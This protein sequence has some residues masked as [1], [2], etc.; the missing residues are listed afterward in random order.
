MNKTSD[1]LSKEFCETES[2]KYASRGS[3]AKGCPSAYNKARLKGWLDEYV[4]L[5]PQRHE[6]GYWTEARCESI[7]RSY[8]RMY[9]FQTENYGA[10]NAAK[11]NGWL[12][13]YTWLEMVFPDMKPRGY[14]EDYQNCF[15]EA[16]RHKTL[17]SFVRDSGGA[18]NSA[19]EHGWL[20]DY[21]WL[22]GNRRKKEDYYT[23]DVCYEIAKS[24]KNK[25]Q[26]IRE[27]P[28]AY[29]VSKENGWVEDYTWLN[30][31]KRKQ[32]RVQTGYWTQKENCRVE[33]L[34]YTKR[35]E[36]R[37]KSN[38][39]Y[40][41]SVKNG[42]I[43]E[44][45]WLE[46]WDNNRIWTKEVCERDARRFTRLAD[47]RKNSKNSY[48]AAKKNGWLPEMVWLERSGK[49][50]GY[51]NEKTCREE[52]L[53]HDT[54]KSFRDE[55]GSGYNKALEN[56]W[57]KEYTWLKR[58]EKKGQE[59]ILSEEK[60]VEMHNRFAKTTEQFIEEAR[61]VHGDKYDYSKTVYV[62]NC[63]KVCIICPE[64]GEFWQTPK[65]HLK[66]NGCAKC[67]FIATGN[68]TRKGQEQFLKEVK[69]VWG[70]ELDFSKVEYKSSKDLVCVVCHKKDKDGKEHGEFYPIP[71]NLLNGHGCPKC[72]IEKNAE[73]SRKDVNKLIEEIHQIHGEKYKI[74]DLSEYV[75]TESK[76]TMR[77]PLHGEFKISP[78]SLLAGQGC[79]KCGHVKGGEKIRLTQEEFI[80]RAKEI[81]G[82]KYDY[83][84]VVYE[85]SNKP[86][87]I[88][89]PKHG[90]FQQ[91]PAGH[92]S[93][94]GC[95]SCNESRN[96]RKVAKVLD[97]NGIRYERQ[98]RFEWLGKQ[99]LDFYLPE[100][101]IGIE[102]QS[103]LHYIDNFFRMSKGEEYAN[104]QLAIVKERDARKKRLCDENGVHLIYFMK[105]VYLEYAN[106]K[107]KNFSKLKDLVD[108]IL[109]LSKIA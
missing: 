51:W 52:A 100:Y 43:E 69:E 89:C 29:R 60:K 62:K 34:K 30:S 96:E 9:D 71:A 87:T 41:S 74:V 93:G 31:K 90:E 33:S 92:L 50:N 4:W 6:K 25:T 99:S 19:L 70:D 108:Y 94:N 61:A 28:T 20:D 49:P 54:L 12:K 63:E 48:D 101:N 79:Y 59:H 18:Y 77:C 104:Q 103:S 53:K 7:A 24:C 82:K 55:C 80:S 56:G 21:T 13:N 73:K 37:E 67:G 65:S 3:F 26:F 102:C 64:H 14:W 75:N 46:K 107:D 97:E 109:T 22:E 81:H 23:R 95:P 58:H 88:I 39:A 85:T 84:K 86:V 17:H 15:A 11:R 38:A 106:P 47:Y 1:Y 42:W 36:F 44:F 2:K 32:N 83:S 45:T 66:G 76:I 5:K 8:Q 35:S 91:T 105:S 98:K 16:Q 27:F 40:K 57:L 72:G 78:H 68:S 10:Y